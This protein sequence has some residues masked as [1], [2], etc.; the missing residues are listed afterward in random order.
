M[1][2]NRSQLKRLF[3]GMENLI[4]MTLEEGLNTCQQNTHILNRQILGRHQVAQQR[5]PSLLQSIHTIDTRYIT[6]AL[7]QSV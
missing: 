2:E 3:E 6:Q 4:G 1:K 5:N 7:L